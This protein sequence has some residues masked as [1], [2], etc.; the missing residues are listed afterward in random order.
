[1]RIRNVPGRR[2]AGPAH[3]VHTGSVP[4]ASRRPTIVD[5]ARA[6]GVSKSLVSAALRGEHGVSVASRDRIVRA[7]EG[8]GYR[9]NGWAQRLVS[10]RSDLVGVLL[11]D[12]RNV[13][14]TDVVNGIEDAAHDAGFD[15]ILSHGRRDPALLET[16][17]QGL[18]DLGVDAVIAVTGHLGADE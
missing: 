6:A 7:A 14:Q 15:V 11:T 13:Y 17:L 9:T 10:G 12:L 4:P 18:I 16:R 3:V 2:D 8:L 1:E 5:V